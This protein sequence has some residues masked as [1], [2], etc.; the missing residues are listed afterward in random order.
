[1]VPE[2]PSQFAG[3][4]TG[5]DGIDV[6]EVQL[7][8]LTASDTLLLMSGDKRALRAVGKEQAMVAVLAG[9]VVCLEAMLLALC[10]KLGRE[11]IR[12]AVNRH[13][14]LDQVF[15]ICFSPGTAIPEDCLRSY[16]RD[17]QAAVHPL[18]LWMPLGVAL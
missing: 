9:K 5:K 15:T 18:V 17:L 2:A 8:A 13:A 6:G 1:M 3:L 7:F 4:L 16:L 11:F 10:L 12:A 14:G